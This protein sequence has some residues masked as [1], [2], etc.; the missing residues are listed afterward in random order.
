MRRCVALALILL[1][2]GVLAGCGGSD[3]EAA[4]PETGETTTTEAAADLPA[5]LPDDIAGYTSWLRLNAEPIPPADAGDAHLGTKNV[6][7]TDAM[8]GDGLFP[9]ETVIVKDAMRPDAEFVGLVAIMRKSAGSAPDSNDWT[10]VEYTREGSDEPFT[11]LASG[12]VC[13]S[14]HVGASAS[15]Y[16]WTI[17]RGLDE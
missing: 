6:Y 7:T 11:E 5:G 17:E 14:C 3:D 16:V 15:D 4:A 12:S 1:G 10:F 13:T 2:L 8:G 9:D